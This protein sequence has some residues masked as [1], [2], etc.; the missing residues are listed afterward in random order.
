MLNF[1]PVDILGRAVDSIC[2]QTWKGSWT[3]YI[4]FHNR[5]LQHKTSVK[6]RCKGLP[7]HYVDI[8]RDMVM[9]VRPRDV[10]L[11][12]A[13][14]IGN[15]KWLFFLDDDDEWYSYYLERM[16]SFNSPFVSCGKDVLKEET[17][18][19]MT[20]LE[21]IDYEGMGFRF[22]DWKGKR[23]PYFIKQ[24]SD[25]YIFRAFKSLYPD[26]PHIATPLYLI[27]QHNDSLTFWGSLGRNTYK[28]V[29]L[30][31]TCYLISINSMTDSQQRK[32]DCEAIAKTLNAHIVTECKEQYLSEHTAPFSVYILPFSAL[33]HIFHFSSRKLREIFPD[34][35]LVLIFADEKPE[36]L[37]LQK[38]EKDFLRQADGILLADPVWIEAY[39]ELHPCCLPVGVP[40]LCTEEIILEKLNSHKSNGKNYAEKN[41][42]YIVAKTAFSE[43]VT[44]LL[45]PNFELVTSMRDAD[46]CWLPPSV[47]K[48]WGRT[49]LEA[50][51]LGIPCISSSVNSVANILYDSTELVWDGIDAEATAMRISNN[52]KNYS[53]LAKGL[54]FFRRCF[55]QFYWVN[56]FTAYTKKLLELKGL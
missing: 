22:S 45:P 49:V 35:S 46:I 39:E 44:R 53:A 25:K 18:L 40:S 19:L 4:G 8:D 43:E 50:Y 38:E 24:V 11:Q 37:L 9:D 5:D 20:Y 16:T 15:H 42:L 29:L 55:S 21:D 23:L 48:S 13:L 54:P 1:Y 52:V 3:L 51:E 2:S 56:S 6:K 14:R 32:K 47:D 27:H 41:R 10:I 33:F 7:V 28:E 34:N 31:G 30:S 17:G 12:E 26:A 36:A